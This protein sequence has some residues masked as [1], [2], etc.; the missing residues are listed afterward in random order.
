MNFRISVN[1]DENKTYVRYDGVLNSIVRLY[2]WNSYDNTTSQIYETSV[3]FDNNEFWFS[4]ITELNSIRGLKVE[5]ECEGKIIKEDYFKFKTIY[6]ENIKKPALILHSPVGIGDNLSATPTIKKVSESY[7]QKITLLTYIPEA[8][9]NNPYIDKIITLD[10]SND[11]QIINSLDKNTYNI[12]NLF[13][14]MSA[15]WR[16]VD[17]KQICAFNCG[18]QLK[19]NELDMEFYPDPYV[20]IENLPEKFICINPSETESSRSWGSENWQKFINLIQEH[21]SVV[22]I[23]KDTYLDPTYVKKFSHVEIK[24]GL[25]LMDHPS[26]NTLS[27]AYHIINKSKTFVTMNNGLHALALCS[28]C[29]ITELATSWNTLYYRT[30]KGIENYNLDYIRGDCTAECLSNSQICVDQIGNLDILNSKYCYLNKNYTCHPTPE[31][32]YKSV[33]NKIYESNL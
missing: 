16:L 26:Q 22:A 1:K 31:Q 29:H 14:L 4:S 27:Q 8:F 18:F 30:R 2:A 24:N 5:V 28:D 15:N 32:V 23:G 13:I 33:L 11:I 19:P 10:N 25:N 20:P 17:S 7:N 12:Y 6:G 3:T 21:I 9:I